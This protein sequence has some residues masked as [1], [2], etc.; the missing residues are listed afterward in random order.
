MG[1]HTEE[2][3]QQLVIGRQNCSK[4]SV[5]SFGS[6][7]SLLTALRISETPLAHLLDGTARF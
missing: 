3:K 4:A 7:I 5:Q 1:G 2:T 6:P